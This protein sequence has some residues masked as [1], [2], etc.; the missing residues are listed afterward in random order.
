MP[1]FLKIEIKMTYWSVD[2]VIKLKVNPFLI[3][4]DLAFSVHQKQ[5]RHLQA[6]RNIIQGTSNAPELLNSTLE[7]SKITC[8]GMKASCQVLEETMSQP[9]QGKEAEQHDA[10]TE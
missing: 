1:L 2:G 5:H 7:A 9:L 8:P 6:A 3:F 10:Q 4:S